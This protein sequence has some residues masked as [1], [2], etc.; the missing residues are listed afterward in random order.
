M[1]GALDALGAE[2]I[3]H[4]VRCLEDPSL[5][6]RLVREGIPLT[7][8]P[9]SNLKLRVVDRLDAHAL[10]RLLEAG[11]LATVNSDDPA[12]FGGYLNQ[13]LSRTFDALG[14][15]ADA[16]HRLARNSLE[17]SFLEPSQRASLLDRLEAYVARF[18]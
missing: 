15:G 14:L 12:Y 4:G 5:V 16:A 9:L 2:R 18:R 17:A 10:G 8:C 13:N 6:A 11:L 7:V 3:D 1:R